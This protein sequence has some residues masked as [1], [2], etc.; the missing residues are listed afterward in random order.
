MSPWQ[1]LLLRPRYRPN[2][3]T[4]LPPYVPFP[5]FI[6]GGGRR[7]PEVSK[8]K[9]EEEGGAALLVNGA[10]SEKT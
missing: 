5:P 6:G 1:R 7:V 4:L 9:E 10:G 3:K 2:T 8:E